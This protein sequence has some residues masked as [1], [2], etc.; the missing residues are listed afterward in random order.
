ML[1]SSADVWQYLLL[2][3]WAVS[4]APPHGGAAARGRGDGIPRSSAGSSVSPIASDSAAASRCTSNSSDNTA[5]AI[6]RMWQNFFNRSFE[7]GEAAMK[8]GVVVVGMNV[9]G[10][11]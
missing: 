10:W 1:T 6:D 9:P 5:D 7:V 8:G 3:V 11:S 2:C 4:M